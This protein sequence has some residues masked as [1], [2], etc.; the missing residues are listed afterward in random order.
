MSVSL[1][2]RTRRLGGLVAAMTLAAAA[3]SP[4]AAGAADDVVVPGARA[5]G[6]TA[7]DGYVVWIDGDRPAQTLM[8]RDAGGTV[9]RVKGAPRARYRSIDLGRNLTGDLVLTYLRCTTAHRCT[10]YSDDLNGQRRSFKGL[11]PRRC[12]LTTA[13]A[14]WRDRVAYGLKCWKPTRAA[15]EERHDDSRSGLYVRRGSRAAKRLRRPRLDVQP[16]AFPVSVSRVD[17]RGTNVAAVVDQ[18]DIYVFFTAYTQTVEGQHLRAWDVGRGG[19]DSPGPS[20][21]AA[22]LSLGVGGM[23]WTLHTSTR[24]EADPATASINRGLTCAGASLGCAHACLDATEQLTHPAGSEP[25][26]AYPAA[27][28]AVDPHPIFGHT[29]YLYVPGTGIVRHEFTPASGYEC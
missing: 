14:V 13:P 19:E 6:M 9:S 3:A 12:Q 4:G 29:I 7:L 25:G 10:A 16:F 2:C 22:G 24:Y 20:S 8:Q 11:V 1:C 28:M 23:L 15:Y 5:Q 18:P 27:S 21:S 26:N 17:L